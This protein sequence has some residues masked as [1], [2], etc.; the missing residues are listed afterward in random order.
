MA[1]QLPPGVWYPWCRFRET[2]TCYLLTVYCWHV[3]T[4]SNSV[5]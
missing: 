3:K 2:L 5:G 4:Q 1:P